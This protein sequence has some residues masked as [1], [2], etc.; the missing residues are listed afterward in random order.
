MYAIVV[1]LALFAAAPGAQAGQEQEIPELTA[2]IAASV[3]LFEIEGLAPEDLDVERIVA[4]YDNAKVYFSMHGRPH[5]ARF[6]CRATDF[7]ARWG[8]EEDAERSIKPLPAE[9]AEEQ[10]ER[11][12]AVVEPEATAVE[13]PPAAESVLMPEGSG[14][15]RA[16]LA[17][18]VT[19]LHDGDRDSFAGYFYSDSD[20]DI[21]QSE[22]T[23]AE[24][25]ARLQRQRRQ[26][27]ASC[28]GIAEELAR[29]SDVT[30]SEVVATGITPAM[31]G[32]LQPLMP[33]VREFYNTA[34]VELLLDGRL[35]SITLEGVALV[36]GA[37]RV[38]GIASHAFPEPRD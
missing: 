20:F 13:V 24:S 5:L 17:Q 36:G 21:T 18:F 32:D 19:S 16:F 7:G 14:G 10:A 6:R 8:L 3:L 27:A 1:A 34:V 29:F 4:L 23:P 15:Y 12:P 31:M 9:G 33:D 26:F 35:G 38:G 37:W 22:G 30:V 25:L 11:E 2:E 28:R